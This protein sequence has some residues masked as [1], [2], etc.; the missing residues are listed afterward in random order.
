VQAANQ[1]SDLG[2]QLIGVGAGLFANRQPVT[3]KSSYSPVNLPA[4]NTPYTPSA[5]Y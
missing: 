4:F 2:G 3:P 1:K 5:G